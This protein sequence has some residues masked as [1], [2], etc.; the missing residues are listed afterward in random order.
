[1]KSKTNL[2]T[3]LRK[4]RPRDNHDPL[5]NFVT[6]AFAWLL[7]NQPAFGR[8]YLGKVLHRLGQ[9]DLSTGQVIEWKPR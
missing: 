2:L 4:Y 8:F 7:I 5:E 3:A 1:M 6:E 9:S